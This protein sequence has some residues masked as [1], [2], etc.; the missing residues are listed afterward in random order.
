MRQSTRVE[1]YAINAGAVRLVQAVDQRTFPVAL[2]KLKPH[3]S[4]LRGE[5]RLH[6]RE[7]V[8]SVRL[9]IPL[10][11]KIQVRSIKDEYRC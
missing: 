11:E 4:K 9:G 8:C 1:H 5:L 7:R 2:E 10:T 3:S 6:R